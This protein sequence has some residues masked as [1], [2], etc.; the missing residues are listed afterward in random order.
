MKFM[1]S[2]SKFTKTD[3]HNLLSIFQIAFL[4]NVQKIKLASKKDEQKRI[5]SF[6]KTVCY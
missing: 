5:I 2:D 3:I 1:N 6:P 4:C